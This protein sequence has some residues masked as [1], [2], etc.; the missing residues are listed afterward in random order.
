MTIGIR[1]R[2]VLICASLWLSLPASA[3]SSLTNGLVAYYPFNGDAN[4]AS[5]FGNN[6]VT[7]TATLVPDRN[8]NP[9]SAYF[10]NGAQN[11]VFK[12]VPLTNV[13]NWTVAAWLNLSALGQ[14]VEAVTVGYDNG[15]TGN[16]YQ[17]GV[18]GA[19]AQCLL[20]GIGGINSAYSFPANEWHHMAIVRTN[21][22]IHIYVD[23]IITSG[24]STNSPI[25]PTGFTIGSATGVRYFQGAIDEVRLYN[26]ALSADEIALFVDGPPKILQQPTTTTLI[27]LSNNCIF[28]VVA[29]PAT[30]TFQWQK[31]GINLSNGLQ[32]SG[33]TTTALTI[34]NVG[35]A[36]AG[37][38]DLVVSNSYGSLTSSNAMLVVSSSPQISGLVAYYPFNGDAGDASGFGYNGF[39]HGA[40]L[41]PD[42]LGNPNSAYFF[43]GSQNITFTTNP[44]TNVDNWTVAA[45]VNL[46][47]SNQMSEA[48]TVGYYDGKTGNGYQLGIFGASVQCL[49]S[50]IDG[51][52]GGMYGGYSFMT[53]EWHCVAMIRTNGVMYLY[54]D[55]VLTSSTTTPPISPTGFTIGSANGVRYFQGA[56]DEVRLYNRALSA[57]EVVFLADGLPRILQ[58]PSAA[59]IILSSNYVFTVVAGPPGLNYQW[60]KDGINLSDGLQI[61]GAT[62][63]AL[64]ISNVTPADGAS[65]DVVIT[66]SYGSVTSSNAILTVLTTNSLADGLVAYY[67]FNSNA[68]DASGF[69]NDG[70]N[71][72]AVL[73]PD[74]FNNPNSAYL[75]SG[76]QNITF[77]NVPLTN[78]DNWT[79][80]AWVK[81]VIPSQNS[82]IVSVGFDD[83]TAASNGYELGI[84]SGQ[85]YGCVFGGVSSFYST[86]TFTGTNA[87][88]HVA[89]IRSNSVAY[90]YLDGRIW[91]GTSTPS[92]LTPTAFYIGSTTGQRYFDGAIDEVRLYNRPLSSDEIN[93]LAVNMPQI[94]RQ[95][96]SIGVS[97]HATNV[98]R[99]GGFFPSGTTFQWQKNGINLVDDDRI[100]GST[101]TSN[102][103]LLDIASTDAGAYTLVASN[104]YGSTTSSNAFLIV[105]TNS[106]TDGLVAYYPFNG[107]AND[108]SGY[109]NNPITNTATLAPD[110]NGN[111]D[112]AYFFDG[113]QNML[114]GSVPLTNVNNWTVA[115]WLNPSTL[116]QN[117]E[118]V[119]IGS[120]NGSTGNGYELGISGGSNTLGQKL[121]CVLNG[122][123]WVDSGYSFPATNEW[124]HVVMVRVSGVIQFY[125]DGVRT[126][127]TTNRGPTL[128]TAF[129]IG[130]VTGTR[131]F[132]GAIDEVRLYNR[133]LTNSE[134]VL[135]ADGPPYINQKPANIVT[136][137]GSACIFTATAGPRVPT[138]QW[139]KNGVNLSNSVQISGVGTTALTLANVSP[140]DAGSYNVF[141][142]N[143]YGSVSSPSGT[144]TV[145]S[146]PAQITPNIVNGSVASVTI[147]DG[148]CG[149]ASVP[150]ITFIGTNQTPPGA[151]AQVTAG[152]VT[153]IV[154]TN[155]G[156]GCSNDLQILVQPPI[157]S[158]MNY[159]L[160]QTN[161]PGAS[162][163]LSPVIIPSATN[164]MVGQSYELQT[165]LTL[166]NWQSSGTA[167]T[168]TNTVWSATNF[169]PLQDATNVFF[170]LHQLR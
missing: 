45:W 148:G 73:V 116:S 137:P 13:D 86:S 62:T 136:C 52:T 39:N 117:G 120:D 15:Y 151:Y 78:A 95:P 44:L 84:N 112:S 57:D 38:Y 28:T 127:N 60:Q 77:T 132:Q 142:T 109:R 37:S 123:N 35:L 164:V 56:I 16:G 31:N 69:G 93:F 115:A 113:S 126:L 158:T 157:Y 40:T 46:S 146:R 50:S 55:G 162:Q 19:S 163:P 131:F 22:V 91:F 53:N 43:N 100:I 59:N 111:P 87:W 125:V 129:S 20:G 49:L 34:S 130:S 138:Y 79:M 2:F 14:T 26:R 5:G 8:G 3:Q 128:P 147:L 101:T 58:Q 63:S 74:H 119:V 72:G 165:S 11:I 64:S 1:L 145:S 150:T 153:S 144:L 141:V 170:R 97:V 36:D 124:H 25:P 47:S 41:V 168:A 167:F 65:Y 96:S 88:H 89:I 12:N 134:I 54:M 76:A 149:Y 17:L 23:G 67:P 27:T 110:R 114:F 103:T 18:S 80:A 159:T 133:V 143:S 99:V 161:V 154:I 4:D 48:V 102:L 94:V 155:P 105:S 70:V 107:N 160:A 33:A 21:G 90:I 122:T 32:I 83:G 7:N 169:W 71:H 51:I 106:L 139:Q 61:S 75:F 85:Y 10:F 135:L 29:T 30:A 42:R 92:P 118:A 82:T 152:S 166:T 6:P 156:S 68:N 24:S 81:P 108:A 140:S 121:S 104:F 98:F 66:N 9:N